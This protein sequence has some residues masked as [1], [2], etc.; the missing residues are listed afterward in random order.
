MSWLKNKF[1]TSPI[2]RGKSN[3]GN[4]KN[5]IR[6]PFENL[7]L[8]SFR[9][10]VQKTG[11]ENSS[12]LWLLVDEARFMFCGF[13]I[14]NDPGPSNSITINIQLTAGQIVRVENSH[15]TQIYGT[16][17][18]DGAIE[19]WFTGFMLYELW[20]SC[21]KLLLVHQ[22]RKWIVKHLFVSAR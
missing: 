8:F 12:N 15:S 18:L 16:H 6:C 19:S 3:Y 1:L 11:N 2:S 13:V 10:S 5:L 4:L 21:F 14:D 20:S 17:S 7:C 9:F 22:I